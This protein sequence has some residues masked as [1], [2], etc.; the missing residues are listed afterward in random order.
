MNPARSFGPDVA[1]GDLSTWWVYL[2]G[3]VVGAMIAVGGRLCA[4]R[5]RQSPGSRRRR[6]HAAPPGR[7]KVTATP[8]QRD[9][10]H[11]TARVM[12]GV[13]HLPAAGGQA[14]EAGLQAR[15][16]ALRGLGGK[17]LFMARVTSPATRLLHCFGRHYSLSYSRK[18]KFKIIFPNG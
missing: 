11:A 7:L 10:P 14:L 12:A 15:S 8:P 17:P 13:L 9:H 16:A 2:I 18:A 1:I 4:A 3:P 6:G 5:A